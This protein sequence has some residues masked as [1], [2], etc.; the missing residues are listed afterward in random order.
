MK[1]DPWLCPP[2]CYEGCECEDRE[3]MVCNPYWVDGY[4]PTNGEGEECGADPGSLVR[5]PVENTEG[6]TVGFSYAV[7]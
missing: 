5:I 6:R 2:H 3:N 1:H 4:C 7:R